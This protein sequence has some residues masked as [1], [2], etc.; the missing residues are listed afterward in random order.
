MVMYVIACNGFGT[1]E[2]DSSEISQKIAKIASRRNVELHSVPVKEH[3]LHFGEVGVGYNRRLDARFFEN[4][5][6]GSLTVRCTKVQ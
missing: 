4:G 3:F 6:I 1:H 2:S 5:L